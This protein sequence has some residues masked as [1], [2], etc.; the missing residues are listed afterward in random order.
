M[1]ITLQECEREL[2]CWNIMFART[3]SC[4]KVGHSSILRQALQVT[5]PSA[6][7]DQHITI[8]LMNAHRI[9]IMSLSLSGLSLGGFELHTLQLRLFNIPFVWNLL[10]QKT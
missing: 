2:S 1:R 9:H 8:I 4:R 3:S 7:I 10:N 6:K 5:D